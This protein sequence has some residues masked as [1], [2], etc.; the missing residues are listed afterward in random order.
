MVMFMIY[1]IQFTP[2]KFKVFLT[3][4]EEHK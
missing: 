2:I 1:P 3:P 4:V